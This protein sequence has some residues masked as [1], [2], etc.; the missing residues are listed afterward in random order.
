MS[1]KVTIRKYESTDAKALADIFYHTIHRINIRDYSEEQVNAWA[2][3]S[4][5]EL[6]GWKH[7]WSK[8]API[9]AVIGNKVVG[10]AEFESKGHID[11]FYVHHEYQGRGVGTILMEAIEDEANRKNI[12]LIYAEVSITA[13]PFFESKGFHV[14]KEQ[15]VII[16]GCELINFVMEK[17]L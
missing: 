14:S 5:L 8:L 16:R 6:D 17:N 9:V 1:H 3:S 11:C 12:H 15:R 2:P 13:K 10:F 7:K 4:S